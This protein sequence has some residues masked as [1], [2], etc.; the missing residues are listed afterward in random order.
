MAFH[1]VHPSV[2]LQL[3]MSLERTIFRR[4]Q[5]DV[6]I[7]LGQE[8]TPDSIY[9][10]MFPADLIV[11][12]SPKLLETGPPLRR[13]EDLAKQTLLHSTARPQNWSVWLAAAGAPGL[14]SPHEL[15]FESSSLA[16]QAA[17]QGI[18][19]AIAQMP[20]VLNEIKSGALTVPF[21]ISVSDENYNLIWPERAPRNRGLALFR[22]WVLAEARQ[23]TDQV[24]AFRR[25]LAMRRASGAEVLAIR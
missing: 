9:R 10:K 14:T 3:T 8:D 25:E 13:V 19:V 11:V 4:A 16:Y 23:T 12:C 24:E 6:A 15:H 5:V 21:P 22:D 7:K 1:S 18:G 2:N 17:I 20:L